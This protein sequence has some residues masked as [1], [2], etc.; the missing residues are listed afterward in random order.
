MKVKLNIEENE[1]V[2]MFRCALAAED[3]M[4][5]HGQDAELT[6][7]KNAIITL[8]SAPF[9]VQTEHRVDDVRKTLR[10]M[11]GMACALR[12]GFDLGLEGAELGYLEGL[13]VWRAAQEIIRQ[14]EEQ[15]ADFDAMMGTLH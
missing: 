1:R 7:E 2:A 15:I 8:L 12:K 13:E 9:D 10:L 14:G 4:A 3:A 5:H 6:K 11:C